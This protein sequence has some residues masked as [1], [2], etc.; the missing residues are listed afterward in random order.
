MVVRLGVDTLIKNLGETQNGLS[1][2]SSKADV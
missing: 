2:P 1:K